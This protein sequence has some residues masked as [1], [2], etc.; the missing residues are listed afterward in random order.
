MVI[1]VSKGEALVDALAFL[2]EPLMRFVGKTA[3]HGALHA[4]QHEGG[5]PEWLGPTVLVLVVVGGVV[6]WWRRSRGSWVGGRAPERPV[7]TAQ[8]VAH[9]RTVA[10][11]RW[12]L[13]ALLVIGGMVW[14]ATTRSPM[15]RE[16]R[17]YL[18]EARKS[19]ELPWDEVSEDW[20]EADVV[21]R[22]AEF[23]M[24][25]RNDSMGGPKVSRVCAVD[26]SAL[27]GIPTMYVNFMFAGERLSRV[28][29]AVPWWSHGEGLAQLVRVRGQPQVVQVQAVAGVRLLGWPLASGGL[30]VYNRD[31]GPNLLDF[32]SV[33]WMSASAC[34]PQ[35]CVE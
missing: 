9:A 24:Q 23:P 30:L 31:R 18:T 19:A 26:V 33:Q 21:R 7:L 34:A 16:Y 15:I 11:Q 20:T 12:L 14:L 6:W 29:T 5:L 22:Y 2:V 1:T 27:N 25:C 28:A 17:L 3:A 35:A 13:L 4:G 32:S 8:E 10:R